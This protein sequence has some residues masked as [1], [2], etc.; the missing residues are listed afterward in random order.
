MSLK[1][2]WTLIRYAL[3]CVSALG[4]L[5]CQPESRRLPY[6]PAKL[7]NWPQPYRG[8]PG[9][10]AHVLVSGFVELP[11]AWLYQRGSWMRRV[12]LPVPVLVLQHPSKGVIVVDSGLARE[13]A[14]QRVWPRSLW[15]PTEGFVSAQAG[16]ELP[17]RLRQAGIRPEAVRWV[18]QTNL[19]AVRSGGLRHFSGAQVVV[20]QAELDYASRQ[21][22][23][24]DPELWAEV[25]QWHLV[26]FRVAQPL[27]TFPAAV[28]LLGD[29]SVFVIDGRGPTPGTI[30]VL[31]RLHHR[32]LLW[33]GDVVPTHAGLRSAAE[34]QGLWDANQWWVRFWQAKRLRDLAPQVEILPAFDTSGYEGKSPALRFHPLPTPV[35]SPA[36]RP[37]PDRWERII[38]RPW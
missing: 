8:V 14:P 12:Q 24:Y 11:Q 5:H 27:G 21:T 31:A 20:N 23:A 37:T 29:G 35:A 19:R 10:T 9:L 2:L 36:R 34:P 7:E 33:A 16:D 17:Q 15:L 30:M 38:P 13:V 4:S 26:D 32:A 22:I 6:I 18:I 1:K 25:R 3:V 28:D